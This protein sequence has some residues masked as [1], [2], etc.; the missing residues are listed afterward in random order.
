MRLLALFALV[1]ALGGCGKPVPADKSA[2]IGEWQQEAMYLLITADGSVNYKRLR[3]GSTTTIEGP[4]RAFDGNN[5]DVGIGPMSTTFVVSKPPYQADGK[6]KMVVDGVE[7]TRID[8]R[9][10]TDKTI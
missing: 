4:L 6:W 8:K 5:F 1:I 10:A 2:Y 7:L 3:G 9:G